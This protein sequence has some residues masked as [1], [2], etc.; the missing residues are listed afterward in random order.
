[1]AELAE[2]NRAATAAMVRDG[3]IGMARALGRRTDIR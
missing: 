3:Q 2:M 1:M